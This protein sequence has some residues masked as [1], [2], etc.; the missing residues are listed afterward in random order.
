MASS[1]A[2]GAWASPAGV[3]RRRRLRHGLHPQDDGQAHGRRGGDR[4]YE[5]GGR[6]RERPVSR[7]TEYR[8][9]P[10]TASA[11]AAAVPVRGGSKPGLAAS[12]QTTFS[13][14]STRIGFATSEGVGILALPVIPKTLGPSTTAAA[15]G[16]S[17]SGSE[18]G[19]G[20]GPSSDPSLT[21]GVVGTRMLLFNPQTAPEL[22]AQGK[23][24]VEIRV[25]SRSPETPDWSISPTINLGAGPHL[26]GALTR[27]RP[28]SLYDV[29]DPIK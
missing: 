26:D 24:L 11:E 19:P 22:P 15:K 20:P 17:Y 28:S 21:T 8:P 12:R 7:S 6:G 29:A 9:G 5:Q 1:L 27:S 18:C 10:T 2:L 4:H 14:G 25:T 16:W 23:G 3:G 13:C